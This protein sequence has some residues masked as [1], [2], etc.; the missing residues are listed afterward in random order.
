[1]RKPDVTSGATASVAHNNA[2]RMHDGMLLVLQRESRHVA[3]ERN[4][5]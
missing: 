4:N 3:D 2:M 5:S 1:M